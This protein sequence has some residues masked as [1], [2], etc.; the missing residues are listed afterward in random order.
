MLR[1][2]R[3]GACMPF[4]HGRDGQDQAEARGERHEEGDTAIRER[5]DQGQWTP[6]VIRGHTP[7]H[8]TPLPRP[9]LLTQSSSSAQILEERGFSESL[10]FDPKLKGQGLLDLHMPK[11]DDGVPKEAPKK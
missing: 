9:G 3:D 7:S 8:R 10:R 5:Q 4:L 1:M 11:P 2:L 6:P